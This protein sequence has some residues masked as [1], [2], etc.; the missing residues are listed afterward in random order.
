MMPYNFMVKKTLLSLTVEFTTK[1]ISQIAT[2][3]KRLE[4]KKNLCFL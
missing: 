2:L 4:D 1:F 3:K